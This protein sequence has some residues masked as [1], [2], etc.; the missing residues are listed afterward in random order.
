MIEKVRGADPDII[1]CPYL[2]NRVPA[3]IWQRWP[4]IIIHPGPVGDRGPSSLDWAITDNEPVWGVT[5]LQAVADMDAGPIWATRTFP[6]PADPPRKSS[7]YNGPVAD[8]AI[9]CILEVLDH[10]AD[11]QF[12]PTPLD[13]ARRTVSGT[14]LRPLM[15]QV[16]RAFDWD[17]PGEHILRHIRAA[18]GAPGV[19]TTIAGQHLYVYNADLVDVVHRTRPGTILGRNDDAVLIAAGDG[20]GIWIGHAKA[21]TDQAPDAIKL[22]AVDV[23]GADLL[24]RVPR[25]A[26]PARIRYIRHSPKVGELTFD[27]YNG[28][29]SPN[30]SR[31]LAAA[32]RRALAQDTHVLIVSG[33]TDA[34]S[35]GIDLNHIH[36]AD[37]PQLAAWA[38]IR[39]INA[40]CRTL[41]TDARRITIAAI[42]GNAGAGGA[43]LPLS[44]DTVVARHGVVLNPYYNIGLSGSE[45][46]SMVL[47]ARVGP[48]VARRLLTSLQP[49]DVDQALRLGLIDHAG[50]RDPGTFNEW[51]LEVA[52]HAAAGNNWASTIDGK[53]TRASNR[54]SE[55]AYAEAVELGKMARDIFRDHLAFA[56]SRTNFVHKRR[57]GQAPQAIASHRS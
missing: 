38:S 23:L 18:D 22:P 15:R 36:A 57:G 46:H 16:D 31:R 48:A 42:T 49:V 9:A 37:N 53:R 39:A 40:V 11:P 41:A 45:L 47:P 34:Y 51:V 3:A 4:T 54:R 8:A 27:I 32:L 24:D 20:T 28:A 43:M 21:T 25:L 14:R 17:E 7:L 29:F 44:A 5:A 6:M 50:P 2:K 12:V 19:R 33:S 10:A 55:I 56:A 30:W 52:A 1:I 26:G 35:N 13:Q